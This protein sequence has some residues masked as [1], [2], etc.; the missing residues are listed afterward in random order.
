MS[1]ALEWLRL[2]G[3]AVLLYLG[4][5][6][7]VTGASALAL[8]L[9]IPQI[10]VGLTVVAYGTSAPEVIVGIEAALSGHGEVALGNIIGSNIANIGLILG[11]TALVKPIAVDGSLRRR[12]LPVLLASTALVPGLL[13]DGTVAH[14]EGA[15]LLA[16]ACLYTAW[17]IRA[18][19]KT[20]ERPHGRS[21]EEL[22]HPVA[23][24][25]GEGRRMSLV[26]VAAKA[27]LGLAILLF[28]GSWF[29][30]GAVA[31]AQGLGM[32]ERIVGLT[33]VAM[34]TSL[35]ELVTSLVA[36]HRGHSDL[37]LG[38]VVG[39][40]IFNVLLCLGSAAVFGRVG[41][42]IAVIGVDLV[43]LGFMTALV[44]LLTRRVRRI[45]RF[46]GGV[47]LLAYAVMMAITI[48]R[49]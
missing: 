48:V 38:N 44:V 36:A 40:N 39:S 30:A 29:V 23:H 26:R 11:L 12:E 18:T 33:I 10:I 27:A 17:M 21:D 20:A 37:A 41:G 14:W 6:W 42:S 24:F 1:M 4:A 34:G 13:L 2:G 19:R 43:A 46:E 49:G 35:P 31:V 22:L 16:L 25:A 7:F 9:R 45:S 3:G 15:V 5:G 8:A 28:G 47:A 32:S